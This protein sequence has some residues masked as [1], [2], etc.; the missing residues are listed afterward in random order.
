MFRRVE[1]LRKLVECVAPRSVRVDAEGDLPESLRV[2][3]EAEGAA[4]GAPF[5][6]TEGCIRETP[7]GLTSSGDVAVE[8]RRTPEHHELRLVDSPLAVEG[9]HAVPADSLSASF[10]ETPGTV[11]ATVASLLSSLSSTLGAEAGVGVERHASERAERDGTTVVDSEYVVRIDA[12]GNARPEVEEAQLGV[13][14]GDE[15]TVRWRFDVADHGGLFAAALDDRG[16]DGGGVR[17]ARRRSG[18][19]QEVDWSAENGRDGASAELVYGSENAADYTEE[20]ERRGIQTPA[21]TSFGFEYGA[22][23]TT[24]LSFDLETDG[25]PTASLRDRLDAWTAF[26]PLPVAPLLSY[27]P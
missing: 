8:E 12:P 22:D 6:E 1:E 25:N 13:S 27:I 18:F 2:S 24:S 19:A 15:T 7:S 4:L 5:F 9:S 21:R 10:V 23:R 14:R 26:V 17:S 20:L 16:Y 3:L 11:R